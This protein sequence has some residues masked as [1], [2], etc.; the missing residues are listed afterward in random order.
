MKERPILFSDLEVPGL[1]E[2]RKTQTRRVIAPQPAHKQ[3]HD[4]QGKR[5]YDGE[6]RLWWWKDRCWDLLFDS[7]QDRSELAQFCP[8]GVTG[9]RL[10]GCETFCPYLQT[11][12]SGEGIIKDQKCIYRTDDATLVDH[13]GTWKSGRFMP[14]WASRIT[15]EL[16]NVRVER[17]QDISEEDAIAE[18]CH[19]TLV[20][21]Q[22]LSD[23]AI[24]DQPPHIK[25][26][27]K[28][29]GCGHF[30]ARY[31]YMHHWNSINAKP[32]PVKEQVPNGWMVTHYES[33]PWSEEDFARLYPMAWKTKLWRGKPLRTVPNPWV[34]A[35]TFKRLLGPE[36]SQSSTGEEHRP[37]QDN[38]SRSDWPWRR[39]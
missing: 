7:L 37:L 38:S 8:F 39:F 6:H 35:L 18:G 34:W 16:T 9:D 30:T 21:Q 12:T 3:V 4:W 36:E 28:A 2:G 32:L 33:F 29:L 10:W 22:D 23:L 15:L 26:L 31:D 1:L 11:I 20:T 19:I 13:H 5:L 24:S 27:G 25:E 14:R 17:L